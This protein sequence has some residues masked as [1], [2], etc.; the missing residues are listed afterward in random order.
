MTPPLSSLV[1]I[2][3]VVAGILAAYF[4]SASPRIAIGL[5]I[6][7]VLAVATFWVPVIDGT[8]VPIVALL[9]IWSWGATAKLVWERR[10]RRLAAVVSD[11]A[12]ISQP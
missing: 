5:A 12:H 11:E 8:V 4:V 10:Q 6:V 9:F 1:F 3:P 2:G 7:L